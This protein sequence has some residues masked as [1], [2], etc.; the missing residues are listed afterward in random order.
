MYDSRRVANYF[1][2]KGL[3]EGVDLTPMKVI[4]LVYISHGWYL[5]Y[6]KKSLISDSIQAWKYGPVIPILYRSLKHYGS[7]QIEALIDID[8]DNKINDSEY[9]VSDE[10]AVFLDIIWDHYKKFSALQLSTITHKRDT[11]WSVTYDG[12][13]FGKIIPNSIIQEYYAAR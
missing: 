12:T 5:A 8:N 9:K 6:R 13:T 2:N 7:N 10:D 4:K 11:P 3:D 1:I